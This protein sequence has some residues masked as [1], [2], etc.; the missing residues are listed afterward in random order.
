GLSLLIF[1]MSRL[2]APSYL[3]PVKVRETIFSSVRIPPVSPEDKAEVLRKIA[4]KLETTPEDVLRGMYADKDSE[5]ILVSVPKIEPV[6]LMKRFNMEQ[7]ETVMLK[8]VRMMI[9]PGNNF[10]RVIRLIRRYGLLYTDD[11]NAIFVSGPMSMNENVERYGFNF[12]LLVRNLMKMEG[13]GA[14]ATVVLKNNEGKKEY[15]YILDPSFSE[16][17]NYDEIE[18]IQVKEFSVP[19]EPIK[20]DNKTVYPD[21]EFNLNEKKKISVIL[22]RP[23]YYEDDFAIVR[24]CREK[25]LNFE[26]FCILSSKEKCPSG[27]ICFKDSIDWYKAKEYL[28]YKYEN[29]KA[30]SNSNSKIEDRVLDEETTRKIIM[31]LENLY[32]DTEAMIDYLDFMGVDPVKMLEKAGFKVKWKGLRISIAR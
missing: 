20:L 23:R 8:A 22:T 19:S 4:D 11:G 32:P 9:V 10:G 14:E 24:E 5:Q 28:R 15:I 25:G 2:K 30:A 13:W 17:L 7:V 12:S 6:E 21:Y 16:Y 31:H 29:I 1:R 18:D 26:I 3:D 27:A